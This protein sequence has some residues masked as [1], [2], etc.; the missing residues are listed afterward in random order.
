M[1]PPGGAHRDG[2]ANLVGVGVVHWGV[3][4]QI[5]CKTAFT[6]RPRIAQL[7]VKFDRSSIP[8]RHCTL[9]SITTGLR[10]VNLRDNIEFDFS[11]SS[12]SFE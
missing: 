1:G 10:K 2:A 11:V 12:N 3:N 8:Q 5:Q 9:T 6:A 4:G 7:I